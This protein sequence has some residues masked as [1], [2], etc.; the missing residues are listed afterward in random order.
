M[1]VKSQCPNC[2]E[3]FGKLNQGK[4]PT[5]DYPRP[6]RAVCA[7]SGQ[8]PRRRGR[9]LWK[10]DPSQQERDFIEEAR[11]ELLLYGFAIVKSVAD[12]RNERSGAM[13]CPLCQKTVKYSIAPSNG[14]MRARCETENC[15]SA[16]E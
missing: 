7:G 3:D 13:E 14:H 10:D 8:R 5:H 4:I 9:A 1:H 6:C 15:I 16:M 12:M 11:F 2:G